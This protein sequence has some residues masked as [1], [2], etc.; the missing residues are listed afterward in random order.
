MQTRFGFQL[1]APPAVPRGVQ[2]TEVDEPGLRLGNGMH[3]K[4]A[5]NLPRHDREQIRNSTELGLASSLAPSPCGRRSN[6][7][8]PERQT[9]PGPSVPGTMLYSG[10]SPYP[11]EYEV[12]G[13]STM[14]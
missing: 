13:G 11:E 9:F 2:G 8:T 1:L 4:S 7:D 14:W 3:A 12:R 6:E 5:A 10:G